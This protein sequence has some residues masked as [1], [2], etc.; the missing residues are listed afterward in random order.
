[1][2]GTQTRSPGGAGLSPSGVASGGRSCRAKW[3]KAW[4]KEVSEALLQGG[5]LDEGGC[6]DALGGA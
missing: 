4:K 2:G 5:R 6:R 3:K 1:M